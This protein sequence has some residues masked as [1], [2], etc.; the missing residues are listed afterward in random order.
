MK[1]NKILYIILLFL[2]FILLWQGKVFAQE[3]GF[4]VNLSLGTQSLFSKK[5]PLII[6][7]KPTI[8]SDNTEITFDHSYGIEVDPSFDNYFSTDADNVYTYKAY[9]SPKQAGNYDIS[10]TV[11]SWG[12]GSNKSSTENISV[13]FNNSLV[14][15][16]MQSGFALNMIIVIIVALLL[17]VA[18]IFF[19]VRG[20]KYL[21]K[22]FKIWM[23][24]PVY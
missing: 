21:M 5:V 24:P 23:K 11:V 6:K 13:S 16:P 4:E 9:I 14:V 2:S 17:G 12:V 22:K 15:T 8:D 10:V 20:L 3:N 19:L 1:R 18:F 7:F